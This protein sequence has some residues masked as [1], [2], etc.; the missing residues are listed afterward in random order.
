MALLHRPWTSAKFTECNSTDM[1]ERISD[2]CFVRRRYS[3]VTLACCRRVRLSQ[4]LNVQFS[5]HN[6][7]ADESPGE[8]L[9]FCWKSLQDPWPLLSGHKKDHLPAF[10]LHNNILL[11]FWGESLWKQINFV[12][13][14]GEKKKR[15]RKI[16]FPSEEKHN[17]K[18]T[19]PWYS[20]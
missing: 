6:H 3:S 12:I 11:F 5:I 18:L 2:S 10:F 14:E 9:S 17:W 8:L 1:N 20:F 4:I 16:Y 7:N 15:L 13:A 19:D